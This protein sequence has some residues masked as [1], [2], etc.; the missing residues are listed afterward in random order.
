MEQGKRSLWRHLTVLAALA[1]V[2]T[3]ALFAAPVTGVVVNAL[4]GQPVRGAK[5]VV[6]GTA[7]EGTSDLDG[8]CVLD[9]PAGTYTVLATKEEFKDYRLAD[10]EVD[11][12]G[13]NFAVV[14]EPAT[15]EDT[16][17]RT[18]SEE[19]TVT[20]SALAS[21]EAALLAERKG[22]AQISDSIGSIEMS[23]NTGSDAAGALKRVT[24][25]SLQEGKFAYVRGLGDRYS[26]TSLNG[27]KIPS[28]EFERKVVPLDLFPSDLIEK[29]TVSKSYTV[30]KPG[31]FAAG[32]VELLTVDLPTQATALFGVS[33]GW[34]S[35]TT[36]KDYLQFGG[37]LDFNGDGGQ[38]LP[39][40]VPDS[41]LVRFSPFSGVGFTPAE[42]EAYGEELIGLWV[43]ETKGSA[44]P[45]LGLK[46]SYGNSFG[47]FGFVVSANYENETQNRAEEQNI[48]RLGDG[49][50]V[51]PRN[52]YDF[53]FTNETV[54]QAYT[55]NFSYN[56]G[57][58]H[59]LRLRSLYTV[60]S[61]AESRGQ[62][63]YF[64]DFNSQIKDYRVSYLQKE[65][66]SSQLSGDHFFQNLGKDGSLLEWRYSTS[67]ATTAENRR[68]ALYQE[69]Q[70][71]RFIFTDNS[72]S[73][74][75]YFNDLKD[76]IDDARL[77]FSTF[78][79]SGKTFGTL[80]A[81]LASTQ[82]DRQFDGRR[83]RFR[84]LNT[85]GIDLTQ[86]IEQ[87]ITAENIG[88]AFE[89]EEI[90]RPT[91]KYS[92]DHTIA[93]AYVQ[94][95]VAWGKW[96]FIG[97]ARY[98]DSDQNVVTFNRYIP[99]APPVVSQVPSQDVL[100]S[101]SLVYQL[102]SDTNLRFSASRTLNRPEYRE[103][104]PF[105]FTNIVGGFA[106]QGNPDLTR[107][108]ITSFDARYEWFPSGGEVMAASVFYKKFTDPIEGI[109]LTGAELTETYDNVEG[110]ENFGVEVEA[111]RNLGS[112]I[113]A[114]KGFTVILNY[115]YIESEVQIDP[116]TTV[117]TN[118]K[119]PLVGQP[120]NVLNLIFEWN[121]PQSGTLVRLLYNLTGEKVSKAGGFGLPDV[122]EASYATFDLVY[123]Q[124]LSRFARGLSFKVSG[125]NLLD[126]AREW[127]QGGGIF[128]RYEPGRGIS[129]GLTFRP[130]AR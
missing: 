7:V 51:V 124:D 63:G 81:G 86:P 73:G 60:L 59:H 66:Q 2:L 56:P 77:D 123:A 28:T 48:F 47:K 41:P 113:E 49:G 95:D 54:R 23:K 18:L 35:V 117:F 76:T 19:I 9:L 92:G 71:G 106:S 46:A 25:I 78:W 57:N 33:G 42:L 8:L 20:A 27:S 121:R 62:E 89:A 36:G 79:S 68:E 70:A 87:I 6:E 29:I 126:E 75:L 40:T 22:A 67:E 31:D 24:G 88:P 64:S 37:G 65:I 44:S 3:P 83:I 53:E 85:R 16:T 43:P 128:R 11:A 94:A 61:D 97:G 45:D 32:A 13:G 72:Q 84:H 4:N 82:N 129:F 38:P 80:K 14:L 98:E 119:R 15:G 116:A 50:S 110:A 99:T 104:A 96:R 103:L 74:F 109:L 105:K 5:L 93:A 21:T 91:D 112:W 34:N 100:P 130:Y 12:G 125:S 10:V 30:D 114:L 111:R 52:I 108:L 102:K 69:I 17:G 115:A 107:A 101:L 58:N 127:T 90:T 120:D 1:A 122:L 26:S 55:G 118:E 39:S